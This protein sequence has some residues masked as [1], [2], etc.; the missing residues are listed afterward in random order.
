MPARSVVI[1][2]YT[3]RDDF[4][5]RQLD[6]FEFTQMAGRA[7]RRGMD[8]KGWVILPVDHKTAPTSLFDIAVNKEYIVSSN[9]RPTY[10]TVLNLL[11]R[12][13]PKDALQFLNKTFAKYQNRTDLS[14]EFKQ[15]EK[16]LESM[17]YLDS[18]KV[19][20]SGFELR[21]IY[22]ESD[23]LLHQFF[24]TYNLDQMDTE[25][26]SA[27]LAA[28]IFERR[29]SARKSDRKTKDNYYLAISRNPDIEKALYVLENIYQDIAS[30][31]SRYSFSP[32]KEP[33][34]MFV[35][36]AVEWVRH[37]SLESVVENG[38]LSAGELIKN[39]R[40]MIDLANQLNAAFRNRFDTSI[41]TE[42]ISSLDRDIVTLSG[43]LVNNTSSI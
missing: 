36:S 34:P 8:E 11:N 2:S 14:K 32:T 38:F 35:S 9:F 31:E 17:S 4:G 37:A 33:D 24:C 10:N 27:V 18:A 5:I 16:V 28:C 29:N 13:E 22:S 43:N 15:R 23:L 1:D 41:F 20:E 26:L 30:I 3:K 21:N 40:T 19:T 39:F 12:F 6:S 7:G 25:S 42:V